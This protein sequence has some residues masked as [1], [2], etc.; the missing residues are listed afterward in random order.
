MWEAFS[1]VLTSKSFLENIP[2]LLMLVLVLLIAVKLG[3]I[4]VKTKHVQ[5]GQMS[6]SDKE[7]TIIREQCDFTHTYLMGLVS[8][9]EKTT[10][11]GKLI[12]GGYFTRYILEA[13]YDE[14]VKWITFNHISRSPAYVHTK[15]EKIK[16][17]VYSMGVREEFKTREF[18][19]R[20]DRWVSEVIE[21]LVRIREL[22]AK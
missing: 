5:I 10:S 18:A 8:K 14:F 6:D 11:D 22:Y 3:I 17:L 2:N 15:Q 7:R 16:A 20:M 13:A 12:H 4:R 19:E 1:N 9:I 21:E